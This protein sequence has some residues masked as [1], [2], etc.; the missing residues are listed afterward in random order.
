MQ[1]NATN[2]IL[3]YLDTMSRDLPMENERLDHMVGQRKQVYCPETRQVEGHSS[4]ELQGK[5]AIPYTPMNIEYCV[6]ASRS[7]VGVVVD[8]P[9]VEVL[10]SSFCDN[11]GIVRS[12]EDQTLVVG[13]QALVDPLDDE[14]DSPNE[15]DLCPSSSSTYNFTKVPLPSDDTLVDPCGNQGGPTLVYEF[16]IT[17]DDVES[18]KSSGNDLD[19]LDYF[20]KPN[21]D[22][23]V[24]GGFSCEPLAAREG[25]LNFEDDTQGE[26]KSGR[27]LSPWLHLPFDPGNFLGCE[28]QLQGPMDNNATNIIL[29]YLDTMS[30]DLAMENESLDRILGQRD[31]MGCSNTCQE[32]GH[33][34]VSCDCVVASRIQV[35]VVAA[36]PRVEVLEP[37]FCD[38]LGIVRSH[39]DQ[40][41][42]VGMQTLVDPLDDEIDSPRKNDLCLSSASTYKLTKVPLP[43]DESI[44]TLVDPCENQGKPTLV[45]ELP[46]T[47]DDLDNDQTGGNDLDVLDCL[48]NL[49]CDFLGKGSFAC[50][51][52]AARGGLFGFKVESFSRRENDISQMAT[53]IFEDMIGYHHLKAQDLA[54]P[55]A[56][57]YARKTHFYPTIECNIYQGPDSSVTLDEEFDSSAVL[58][59]LDKKSRFLLKAF[60]N[61]KTP[62]KVFFIDELTKYQEL[63]NNL[64]DGNDK[65]EERISK[66]EA[67]LKIIKIHMLQQAFDLF[68]GIG[69]LGGGVGGLY[70]GISGIGGGGGGLGVL[71]MGIGGIGGI[72]GGLGGLVALVLVLV[73]VFGFHLLHS[74]KKEEDKQEEEE[75]ESEKENDNQHNDKQEEEKVE[76]EKEDDD[77]DDDNASLMEHELRS[78][79]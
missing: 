75:V 13:M 71:G 74:E 21:C 19:V 59:V 58:N 40:N 24:K 69:V 51:C 17:S 34:H 68:Q 4:C 44:H 20:G 50:E 32:E 52:L 29:A 10:E 72:G 78:K 35:G 64:K 65:L 11:L 8:F 2:V 14:I 9:R 23:L 3:A 56:Q 43:S 49:N 66:L 6:V 53:L 67:S 33:S 46:T 39:E 30:R 28:V 26:N 7:Q 47:S 37:L 76:N 45:Y 55:R 57:E 1:N 18:D 73:V 54:T 79:S 63:Y 5:N 60:Y 31:K 36:L 15:N 27:D 70:G 41:L 42:V 12:H 16:P 77:Q 38:T 25:L 62:K 61:A 22:C 48:G